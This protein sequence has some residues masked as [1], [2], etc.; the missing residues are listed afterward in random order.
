MSYALDVVG[1]GAL[2]FDYITTKPSTNEA[3]ARP[4]TTQISEII[5]RSGRELE[6]GTEL[7][8]DAAT[9]YSAIEAASS[10]APQNALGG[11]AFNAI[12]AIAQTHVG[13]RLGY[14]GIAGHAPVIGVSFTHQFELLGID[15]QFVVEDDQQPCGICFSLIEGGDRTLLTHIGANSEMAQFLERHFDAV[16]G[17]LSTARVVHVTSFLDDEAAPHLLRVLQEVKRTNTGTLICFDPGHV[18]AVEHP[19]AVEGIIRVS[20]YLILNYREFQAL[21][22][23]GSGQTNDEMAEC[24]LDLFDNPSSMV[25]V[26]RPTGIWCYRQEAGK[27]V[28]NFFG[29][30]PLPDDQIQDSTGA[31]DVFAAGLLT[32]LAHD[33]LQVELGSLLGM[34]LA[35]HTLGYVGSA[36][37]AQFAAVTRRLHAVT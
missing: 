21:G 37:H 32:V 4:L 17:Y 15:H 33:R 29:Q 1:I 20:D 13:L 31:G 25:I 9:I 28:G 14:V 2:N 19:S 6:L 24:V 10:A 35:R 11:S 3:P 27:V 12:H 18:W 7:D 26:K 16:V 34:T 5:A 30:T 23:Q 22:G 36:G 8:V